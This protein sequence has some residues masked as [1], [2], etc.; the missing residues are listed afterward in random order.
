MS[1][2]FTTQL[3]VRLGAL[4][5][6]LAIVAY[7]ATSTE[8]RVI[9]AL[10][11]ALAV[12]Q[13]GLVVR[14]VARTNRELVRFVDALRYDDASQSFS[15][16]R[17]GASFADLQRSLAQATER[18]GRSR[19][20][21]AERRRYL[22]T[23]VEHVPVALV[24]LHDDGRVELLNSAARR[25]LNAA[26]KSSID[27][28]DVY[29]AAFQRD[30]A[31]SRAGGRTLT[32]AT[33]DGVE[34]HLVLSTTQITIGA[35]TQRL[36]SLQDIQSEL[37]QSELSA[38]QD[39]VRVL[40]HEIL[41]S[42]TPIASLART[43]DEI[44]RDL[45]ERAR[46]AP[47]ADPDE[48]ADLRDAVQTVARRSDGLLAF[49]RS[50]RQLTQLPPP[51]LRPVGV[52]EYFRRL[53]KLVAA[54]WSERGITL[55]VRDPPPGLIIQADEGLLDQAMLNLLRNAADAVAG[56]DPPRSVW[57]AS[58]MS[59]RGRPVIEIADNGPGFADEIRDKMFLPFFT[60]KADG[61]GI[62]LALVRQ[63]MLIHKGAITASARPG[64][65][66]L[67]RLTF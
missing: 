57:L 17:L 29:G 25:L 13:A 52:S 66:A 62:G 45:E 28:L 2:R 38:W 5:A 6:L 50:Y 58:A 12:L 63:I 49:V 22:E 19:L 59:E 41:N 60:T 55:D 64:G 16:G 21:D 34:R 15:I 18:F 46:S 39:M 33:I 48:M 23:L 9:P 37:D 42:L 40:S 10:V 26:S 14:F 20:A 53:E 24:A 56:R 36:T 67:F 31:Q 3:L 8:F 51:S 47:S 27:V 32:R 43:A 1:A 7:T 65:G 30:L 54:D 35:R 11:G 4:F 61:S 44:V